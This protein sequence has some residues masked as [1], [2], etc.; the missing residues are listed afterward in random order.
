MCVIVGSLLFLD[1]DDVLSKNK[2][3][4]VCVSNYLK[5]NMTR[6]FLVKTRHVHKT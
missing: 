3:Q 2:K 6:L 5:E 1:V 4:T